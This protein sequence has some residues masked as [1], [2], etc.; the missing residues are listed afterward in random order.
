MERGEHGIVLRARSR[1]T[2][3]DDS[4]G[5][6]GQH[7]HT[8]VCVSLDASAGPAHDD[9]GGVQCGK[10]DTQKAGAGP[11]GGWGRGLS[12]ATSSS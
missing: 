11:T 6:G 8:S 3:N 10:N 5:N 12:T 7:N 4:S 1:S 9:N 2:R